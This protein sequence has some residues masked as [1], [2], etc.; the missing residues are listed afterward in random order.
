[1]TGPGGAPAVLALSAVTY[2]RPGRDLLT[3]VDLALEPGTSTVIT[4]RAGSGKS[5]LLALVLGTV[6][7]TTG[8]V[9]I[10]GTE[11]TALSRTRL[12]RHRATHVGVL[13]G[14]AELL[15]EL[16]AVENVALA[17]LLTGHDRTWAIDRATTLLTGLGV[18]LAAVPAA[19][20]S[21]GE[22][23]RTALARALINDPVLLLADEPSGTPDAEPRD[24]AAQLFEVPVTTGCALLLVTRDPALAARADRHLHLAD[25]VLRPA[26]RQVA[27][28]S[29]LPG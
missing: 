14:R 18:P 13:L 15:P 17:S 11:I 27:S 22:R 25:G 4:G 19:D 21:G 7:P 10:A 9:K 16:T 28:S 6:R 8:S 29:A 5:T 1:M 20:L 26:D 23:R 2:R 3:G 12:A 24:L